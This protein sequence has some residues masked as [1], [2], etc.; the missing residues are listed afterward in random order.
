MRLE[1]FAQPAM[2]RGRPVKLTPSKEHRTDCGHREAQ[3]YHRNATSEG[4]CLKRFG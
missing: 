3:H 2:R 1:D 4:D